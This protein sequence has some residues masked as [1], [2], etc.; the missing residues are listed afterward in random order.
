MASSK[1]DKYEA[2]AQGYS[3]AA[4]DYTGNEGYKNAYNQSQETSKAQTKDTYNS[5]LSY[6]RDL[7]SATNA[8]A[9]GGARFQTDQSTKSAIEKGNQMNAS[10]NAEAQKYANQLAQK[11]AAGAQAQSTTAARA[12]GMNKAQA[13][14]MGSQQ[15]A[16]A[17]QNAYGNAYG[18]QLGNAASNQNTQLANYNSAYENQA[19]RANSNMLNQQNFANS[20][21]QYQQ[22]MAQQSGQAA[23]GAAGTELS[24]GQQEGQNEYNRKWGNAGF[25]TG[26]LSSD[27]RLKKY[28]ECSKKVVYKTPSKMQSLKVTVKGDK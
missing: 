4:S 7:T 23:L 21:Q 17:Y 14:M 24:A 12:A 1:N 3:A 20:N 8:M 28:K 18:Q 15:N 2:A 10:Q 26:L 19:N 9:E 6:G 11:Q 16:N 25:W 22:G 5:G 27:E 13:A